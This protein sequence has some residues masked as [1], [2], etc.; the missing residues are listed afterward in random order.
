MKRKPDLSGIKQSLHRDPNDFLDGADSE[1]EK[2]AKHTLDG[3]VP[4]KPEPTVQKL[5]RL[6][7]DVANALK[8][9]AARSSV[10][11]GRRVTETEIVEELIR[12]RC[13]IIDS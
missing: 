13:G 9:E 10:E 5:F 7:W 2:P 3:L 8:M 11:L 1:Q 6:R 4:R 12:Q